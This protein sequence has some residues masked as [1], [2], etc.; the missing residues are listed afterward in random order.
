MRAL[1]LAALAAAALHGAVLVGAAGSGAAASVDALRSASSDALSS[2]LATVPFSNGLTGVSV[3][4]DTYNYHPLSC[5]YLET[6]NVTCTD[7]SWGG[8]CNVLGLGPGQ[9]AGGNCTAESP[10]ASS[11]DRPGG[12][13]DSAPAANFSAC[14]ARC[15]SQE[16][17]V[18]WVYVT[19]LESGTEGQCTGG[20]SCCW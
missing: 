11:I 3:N 14:Q 19:T 7:C 13:Y 6:E 1:S 17:C 15:C 8:D 4:A 12:D 18:A 10:A 5:F 20:T 2:A 16:Q 9:P